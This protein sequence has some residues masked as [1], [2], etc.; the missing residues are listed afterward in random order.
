MAKRVNPWKNDAINSRAIRT[1][2]KELRNFLEHSL[3]TE[4]FWE[5]WTEIK[6]PFSRVNCWEIMNCRRENCPAFRDPDC[7]CW[8]KV[9]TLCNG[10]VQGDFAKKYRSCFNCE[11][12]KTVE[13]DDLWALHENI[14]TLIHHL[15]KRDEKIVRAAITDQLTGAYNRSYFNEYMDKRLADA[16]RYEEYISFIMV[17]L[18]GFKLLNDNHGHHAGDVVLVETAALLKR[19]VRK[20]DMVFRYGGDEFLIILPRAD[21]EQ[22]EL[23]N[24]RIVEAAKQWNRENDKYDDFMLSLSTGCATWNRGDDLFSKIKEADAMMYQEKR[25]KKASLTSYGS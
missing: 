25:Q 18:D 21:C 14:N 13:K 6:L 11:V 17:D 10:E 19:V 9:G 8:L 24:V 16:S 5:K 15:K 1:M 7:R 22:A 23:V 12:L 4:S 2:N 20:P 3:S